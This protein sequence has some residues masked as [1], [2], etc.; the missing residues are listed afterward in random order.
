M[1]DRVL[2]TVLDRSL[3]G[4]Y[5]KLGYLARRR[6]WAGWRADP[7]TGALEGR[8]ALVTGAGGG[9]GEATAT[10]LARLGATVHL[11][12]RSEEKGRAAQ[13]RILAAIPGLGRERLPIQICDLGE[14][15]QVRGFATRFA[16]EVDVLDVLVHN[17]G[18]LPSE[19]IETSEGNELTL[20][21][22]VL[23]PLLLTRL[24]TDTLA[25][26]AER[27]GTAARVIFVSSGGMYAQPLRA[28]DLQFRAGSY[29]GTAAY[30]RTKRM[31]VV[32]TGLLADELADREVTVHALHPGWA[33]TP[34]VTGSLPAFD[35]V[36]GPALRT[37]AQGADTAV[38]LAAAPAGML[39][40]G[41]FWHDRT[42]RPQ[43]YLSRTKETPARRARFRAE[44]DR[45]T[46]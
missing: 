45:L 40:T 2:D 4:G 26:G 11:L 33:A 41:L 44:L 42:V 6:T 19:R 35:R 3:V 25:A 15:A 20:A 17:A 46:G 36:V 8:T 38:W 28:D 27:S 31:Q 9:L 39:G 23:G 14:L 1:L 18:V 10:G 5:S 16:T 13:D 7:R 12:V 34:G 43:H 21:V 37:P 30:A 29:G 24:L 22:H 32:L